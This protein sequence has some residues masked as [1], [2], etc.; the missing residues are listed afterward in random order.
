MNSPYYYYSPEIDPL[1]VDS[2]ENLGPSRALR[3]TL[4]CGEDAIT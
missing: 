3:L 2:G 4:R 1:R